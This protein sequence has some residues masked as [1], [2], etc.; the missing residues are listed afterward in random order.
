MAKAN[1]SRPRLPRARDLGAAFRGHPLMREAL[2]GAL[3]ELAV[4]L[5]WIYS[6]CI[7]AQPALKQQGADQDG[8]I[9][10]C[11]HWHA[12]EPVIACP[13]SR[14]LTELSLKLQVASTAS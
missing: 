1:S 10:T 4:Q 5:E 2:R 7:T 14:I 8:D 9:E 11:L 6:T 3:K 12:S 13:G